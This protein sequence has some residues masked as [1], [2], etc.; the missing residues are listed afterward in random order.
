MF[1]QRHA[2]EVPLNAALTR[3]TAA[4][5]NGV[6][7]GVRRNRRKPGQV[8]VERRAHLSAEIAE[9]LDTARQKSGQLSLGLYLELLLTQ[10]ETDLGALP[11]LSPTLDGTEVITKRAA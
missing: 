4:M 9:A 8:V 10:L 11:V 6:N 7:A 2:T 3:D 1:N 5:S